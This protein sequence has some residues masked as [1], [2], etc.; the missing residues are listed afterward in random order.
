MLGLNA[1]LKIVDGGVML[2]NKTENKQ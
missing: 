1:A 2:Q